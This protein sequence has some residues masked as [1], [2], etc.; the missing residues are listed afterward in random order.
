MDPATLTHQVMNALTPVLPYMN[1]AGTAIATKIGEDVYERG[2][3]LYEVIR[4]RFAQE[5]DEKGSK[6]LQAYVDDPDMR[7]AVE[8]KLLRLV[9]SDPTLAET[10]LRLLQTGPTMSIEASDQAIVRKN[11]MRNTQEHGAQSI[12]ARGEAQVEDNEMTITYE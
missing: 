4:A 7:S 11:S 5:P 12:T 8:V 9:Q 3:K 10:L 6:A 1:S 2:K